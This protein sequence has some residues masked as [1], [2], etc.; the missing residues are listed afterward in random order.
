MP[1][2]PVRPRSDQQN[3][4]VD[5]NTPTNGHNT[6]TGGPV[7]DGQR[8]EYVLGDDLPAQWE[9]GTEIPYRLGLRVNGEMK[10]VQTWWQS[11]DEMILVDPG[12]RRVPG[13]R[14]VPGDDNGLKWAKILDHDRESELNPDWLRGPIYRTGRV[15]LDGPGLYGLLIAQHYDVYIKSLRTGIPHVC[16]GVVET[17]MGTITV[18]HPRADNDARSANGNGNGV[19]NGTNGT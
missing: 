8:V 11:V 15:R 9:L 18:T 13:A 1:A 14:S 3:S 7:P 4:G 2:L 19:S 5:G 6:G 12:T 17:K 10:P 16:D